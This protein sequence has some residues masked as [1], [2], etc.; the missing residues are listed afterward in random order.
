[1]AIM[2]RM[3]DNMPVILIGLVVVFIITIVFEWG[4]DYLGMS[5]TSDTIGVI[6]GKKIKYQEFSELV[7][8]QSEQYKQQ[9]KQEPDE[10]TLRQIREQVWNNL[11][12]QTLLNR[13]TKK[14]GITV[15]DQEIID[16]VRG[17]NPP[18]FLVQQFRD[19]TGQFRRDAY[20]NALNDPQQMHGQHGGGQPG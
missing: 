19:S 8:Q 18:E 4:M 1:M 14:A 20:E 3:R 15:T 13:E 12:T 17:E 9:S 6:D 5:R 2:T 16:W 10:N 11:V 7:R